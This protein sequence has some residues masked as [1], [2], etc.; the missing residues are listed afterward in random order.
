MRQIRVHANAWTLKT[1]MGLDSGTKT[2]GQAASATINAER[3]DLKQ[4]SAL[5]DFL[6]LQ[7]KPDMSSKT[8]PRRASPNTMPPTP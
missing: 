1:Q 6:A 7:E 2:K 3:D 4:K 5:P 8:N